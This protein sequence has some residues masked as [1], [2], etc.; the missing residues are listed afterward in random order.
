MSLPDL[1]AVLWRQR[2]LLELLTYRLECEQLMLAGGRTRWLPAATT[3]VEILLDELR[4]IEMQRAAVSDAAARELELPL[5]ATLEELAGTAQ[6]PWTE[7]LIE[8]RNALVALC[9]ELGMLAEASRTMTAAG[10]AAVEQTLATVGGRVGA[11]SQGYD[12]RGRTDMISGHGRSVVVDR[13][14]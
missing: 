11:S 1:A 10:L 3:E 8:H 9:G 12:A 5:G 6:P 14:L 7:V 4:V 2:E 13:A